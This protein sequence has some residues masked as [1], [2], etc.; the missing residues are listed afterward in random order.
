[1]GSGSL[2]ATA[3]VITPSNLMN[4]T[5]TTGLS[6]V[7]GQRDV[8]IW[9]DRWWNRFVIRPSRPGCRPTREP[10]ISVDRNRPNSTDTAAGGKELVIAPT[11]PAQ[12]AAHSLPTCLN[13]VVPVEGAW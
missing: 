4:N 1:M 2:S 7:T 12:V 9:V 6:Q 8:A 10:T 5:G 3:T 13:T 11:T